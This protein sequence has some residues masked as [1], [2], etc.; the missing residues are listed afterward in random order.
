M[1]VLQAADGRPAV[2]G[3]IDGRH[4]GRSPGQGGDAGDATP[5]GGGPDLEAVAARRAAVPSVHDEVGAFSGQ[6][7]AGGR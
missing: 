3:G 5:F 6:R 1:Q 4:G 2:L 7:A